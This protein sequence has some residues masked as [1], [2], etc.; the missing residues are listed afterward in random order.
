MRN[1][2]THIHTVKQAY[3]QTDGQRERDVNPRQEA[4]AIAWRYTYSIQAVSW[5]Y[6]HQAEDRRGMW[7]GTARLTTQTITLN[8]SFY[9]RYHHYWW[10]AVTKWWKHSC[11]SLVQFIGEQTRKQRTNHDLAYSHVSRLWPAPQYVLYCPN[12]A[13]SECI[14]SRR[15]TAMV[16]EAVV[17]ALPRSQQPH[18]AVLLCGAAS[19]ESRIWSGNSLYSSASVSR[20][21]ACRATAWNACSTFSASLA[22]VSK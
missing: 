14:T 9:Y 19:S 1:Q 7:P 11:T 15:D 4:V 8:W 10:L 20:A 21:S 16:A 22:L 3:K 2:T 6:T 17:V 18:C 12:T 5:R 13:S